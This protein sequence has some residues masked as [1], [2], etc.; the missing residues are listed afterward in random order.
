MMA[1]K[2]SG[3]IPPLSQYAFMERVE[4]WVHLFLTSALDGGW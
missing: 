4:V 2:E 1:Y 3:T